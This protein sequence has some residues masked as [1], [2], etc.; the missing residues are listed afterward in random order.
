[1]KF[2]LLALLFL[3]TT[4]SIQAQIKTPRPSPGAKI[5]QNVGLTDITLDYSRPSMRG[6]TIF[7]ELV[8]FGKIWRTG[9]NLRTKITFSTDVTI[10]KKEL[11]AGTYAI[12]TIPNKDS[13]EIIFYTDYAGGGAPSELDESKVALKTSSKVSPLGFDMQTFTMAFGDMGDPDSVMLYIMWEQ[14][15]VGIKI[16]LHTDKSV[17]ASIDKVLAGPAAGDY[18]NA[19]SYYYNTDKDL[20]QALEWVDKAVVMNPKAFWMTRQKSL[21]QAKMGDKK[22]AIATAKVSI[23]VA[24]QEK[25]ENFVKM[26]EK[27]IAEWSK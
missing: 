20:K 23:D 17:V 6:R 12:F 11:K 10:D 13:W 25:N 22:G 19:A 14:S 27:S 4:V 2:K 9:A 7:G 16:E 21:I 8:P 5:E 15:E 24:K 26:N 3:L 1:M 18:Y